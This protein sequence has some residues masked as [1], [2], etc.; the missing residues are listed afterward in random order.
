MILQHI[1]THS[2]KYIFF[3]YFVTLVDQNSY[4][5]LFKGNFLNKICK[6]LF[7]DPQMQ[8]L[9]CVPIFNVM[10][11]YSSY[12]FA[13]YQRLLNVNTP[14][15]YGF[16]RSYKLCRTNKKSNNL[17]P[18]VEESQLSPRLI[19]NRGL[20]GNKICKVSSSCPSIIAPTKLIDRYM[21]S[22]GFCQFMN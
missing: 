4:F 14:T 17:W 8:F 22:H 10:Y 3:I 5:V 19:T 12:L 16:I 7:F 13:N 11:Q 2:P 6:T 15:F 9:G 21:K 1:S 18:V 20:K